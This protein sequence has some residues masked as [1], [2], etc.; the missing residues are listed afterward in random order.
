MFTLYSILNR[1]RW[2][3]SRNS[4]GNISELNLIQLGKLSYR[5][6][7]STKQSGQR[8]P[9]QI[10]IQRNIIPSKRS[11]IFHY[12]W[13]KL[14]ILLKSAIMVIKLNSFNQHNTL[15]TII[16]T[17]IQY[18]YRS[19]KKEKCIHHHHESARTSCITNVVILPH[20]FEIESRNTQVN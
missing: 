5:T 17:S 13:R 4:I 8:L 7:E 14:F 18:C 2:I 6:Q 9:H 15:S 10:E 19:Q 20:I 16:T 1:E 3:Q 12:S 11:S